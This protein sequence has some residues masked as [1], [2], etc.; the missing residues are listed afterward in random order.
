MEPAGNIVS[1]A[2]IRSVL[3]TG[4]VVIVDEAYYEFC[5]ETVAGLVAEYENLVVLRTFS[6][7]AGIAGLRVGYGLM[8]AGLVQHIIDIKSPY[9][10]NA[11][12]EAAALAS[13]EDADTLLQNVAKIAAE[14]DR[15][16]TLLEAMDGVRPYPSSGNYVLCEFAPGRAGE[17]FEGLAQCGIF[18][19]SFS[20]PRL[21]D[22]LRI[23]AGT[24]EQTDAV[25]A[26]LSD[27]V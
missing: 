19:R 16:Y 1:E 8:S 18:V 11:G 3:E 24:A 13:L 4:L 12:A 23:S 17:I 7:W 21:R 5:G 14:R 9:N 20:H 27:L 15:L 25:I 22:H 26:A 6:K 10:V 2:Q